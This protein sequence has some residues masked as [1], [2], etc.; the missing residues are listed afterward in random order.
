MLRLSNRITT[1]GGVFDSSN[2]AFSNATPINLSESFRL[3]RLK[4]R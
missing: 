1:A 2:G 3:Y 4:H